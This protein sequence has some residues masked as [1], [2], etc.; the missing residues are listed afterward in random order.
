MHEFEQELAEHLR[1]GGGQVDLQAAQELVHGLGGGGS[2]LRAVLARPVGAAARQEAHKDMNQGGVRHHLLGGAF[3]RAHPTAG[4]WK[5]KQNLFNTIPL[6]ILLRI[7][8]IVSERSCVLLGMFHR[9]IKLLS[10]KQLVI[11][12]R[13]KH[14]DHSEFV[15]GI[16]Q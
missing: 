10:L 7:I 2:H 9:Y 1:A 6:T 14:C 16:V 8:Q 13:N 3:L 4:A 5:S 15:E 12:L 11:L